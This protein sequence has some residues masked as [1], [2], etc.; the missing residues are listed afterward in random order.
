MNR[1]V[2]AY[3]L[4]YLDNRP[5]VLRSAELRYFDL[6]VEQWS[7]ALSRLRDAGCNAVSSDVPW[8]WHEPRPGAPDFAGTTHPARN[9]PRFLEDVERA[10]LVFLARPGPFIHAGH[11]GDGFPDW[12]PG[13]IPDALGRSRD[14]KPARSRF[15]QAYAL[16]HPAFLARV[17][18][19]YAA[20]AAALRP[21]L[22]HPVVSWQL[23][24]APGLAFAGTIGRL[25][26]NADTVARYRA[27]LRGRYDD[28]RALAQE[29]RRDV[30]PFDDLLPPTHTG[31]HGE[32]QDWQAFLEWWVGEY[33]DHLRR[34]AVALEVEVPLVVNDAAGYVS[35]QGPN[36]ARRDG[37]LY[38]YDADAG[39]A[40]A[41]TT[42]DRSVGD[43]PFAGSY[44]AARFQ[45]YASDETPLSCWGLGAGSAGSDQQHRREYERV[46]RVATLHALFA[47]I[48]HGLKGYDLG[49][50]QEWSAANCGEYDTGP[51]RSAVNAQG[52]PAA[53]DGA[54]AP[55]QRWLAAHEEE[56][57]ASAEVRDSLAYLQYRP[58]ARLTPDD[59]VGST[60]PPDR[61]HSSAARAHAGLYAVLL[62]AGFNPTCV[63]LEAIEDDDLAEFAAA[64]FPSRGYL[65][66][67]SY[68][69]LVV[70]TIR[71]GTLLTLPEPV[72]RQP[73][74]TSF[75]SDFL[76][77]VAP[78]TVRPLGG[79]RLARSL[80]RLLGRARPDRTIELTTPGGTSLRG[81]DALAEFPEPRGTRGPTDVLLRHGARVAGYRAQVRSGTSTL[82][83]TLL[84]GRYLTSRY[85]AL[86]PDERLAL[87]RIA[88]GLFEDV[89]P[90]AFVADERL[91]VEAV[92]RLSPDG[93]C[94]LFVINRLGAQAGV[95]RLA[96]P[97]AL[98]VGSPVEVTVEYTAFGSAAAPAT[99]GV[100]LAV[101]AQDVLVVRLR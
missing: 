17:D 30:P 74:G 15:G 83:G 28:E 67:N 70:F 44:W 71:G 58:Y 9:L 36:A 39:A 42:D 20:V 88:A 80:S 23:D 79:G 24:D 3:G 10:D 73:D 53:P 11:R 97:E 18:A 47:G 12:L 89:V 62:T 99:G 6:P 38:G 5:I 87:R 25:D 91:E 43:A 56:L 82:L 75:K 65:D 63:D 64:I 33:L 27:F 90:R 13:A 40:H 46:P 98:N 59:L 32:L 54:L 2:P 68:G 51:S 69:K 4:Y 78:E 19:W 86:A 60:D 31:S 26:F 37:T 92:A 21:F 41:G 93:G 14:G 48:A 57:T 52:Q 1:L 72:T 35:P 55:L 96:Q 95:L 22:Q 76:W 66:L 85:A 101:K 77:P 8:R 94:L 84:G 61:Q 81:D 34:T 16:L 50:V 49:L 7:A 45:P 29:W 100:H